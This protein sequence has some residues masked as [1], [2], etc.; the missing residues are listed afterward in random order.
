MK[1]MERVGFEGI[2]GKRIFYA[3][4]EPKGA[5]TIV[6]FCH[7]FSANHINSGRSFVS[8]ARIL[9]KHH[10]STLR[11]DMP[12]A[13]DSEGEFINVS[14]KRWVAATE[15]FVH[16]AIKHYKKIVL[17]GSSIGAN[18]AVSVAAD[19]ELHYHISGLIL[20]M[21]DPV[22][23]FK[24]DPDKTYEQGGLEFKGKFW[25][26]AYQ[27]DFLDALHNYTGPVQ[28]VYGSEDQ[29]VDAHSRKAVADSMKLRHQ[30]VLTLH[31][32]GHGK[33]SAAAQGKAFA[34]G[35]EFIDKEL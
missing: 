24:L 11:F 18:V 34:A 3:L 27:A 25:Q 29:V 6:I 33:W 12:N 26:E 16:S 5:D 15:H 21:P 22:L 32:E 17:L 8:F 20:W 9:Q 10:V 19:P 23:E 13:G 31:G 4:A 35:V 30:P 28:V 2:G 14:F 7:G 1:L